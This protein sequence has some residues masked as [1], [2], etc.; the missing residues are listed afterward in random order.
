MRKKKRFRWQG[1]RERS[2][3][4]LV[5]RDGPLRAEAILP[6][7]RRL[8]ELLEDPGE[9]A[10]RRLICPSCVLVDEYG[11]PRLIERECS[12]AEWGTYLPPEQDRPEMTA[13]SEK[14]YALGMLMLYMASGQEKKAEA[15]ISLGG[16]GLHSVIRRCTAFDPM[17]RFED[18]RAVHDAV[19]REMR[20]GR[21]AAPVVLLLLYAAAVTALVFAAWR[22][23]G[24][25]GAE[26][27]DTAGYRPGYADGYARGSSAAPGIV[28]RGAPVNG[29]CGS[30]SGN[31]AAPDGPTA[32]YSEK[33]V[34]FLL[35]GDI[36]RMDAVTGKT[37]L[38]R[39]RS[40]AY[41]LQYYQGWLYC[42]TPE[43]ILRIDPE[44]NREEVYCDSLG[45]RLSIFD[46]VFYLYDSAG[47]HYLYR[48][49]RTGKSLKQ[50]SGAMEYRCLNV[51]GGKLYY[52]DPSRGNGICS[53]D[54]DGG[55]ANLISSSSYE[56]FCIY[57]GKITV[58]TEY[59]LIR[60]DLNGGNPEI[61]TSQPAYFP[62]ASESGVFYISG[63]GR[64]LEWMSGD[65]RTRLTVVSSRTAS[66][67][68]AGQWILYQNEDDGGRLWR[69]RVSGADNERAGLQQNS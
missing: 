50:I 59:G 36:L 37:E 65:G 66:F 60:M 26:A 64:T 53:S 69:V 7:I 15:E 27:G 14:V 18:V 33:E 63:S 16:T 54:P 35:D 48:I 52:I 40:G 38:L 31:Y 10:G 51:A 20:V 12:R 2:I 9:L 19:K 43:H 1:Q 22:T 56:S 21:K 67:Q 45:G 6:I 13:Q 39:K 41:S 49:S 23:G 55:D 58:G 68:L 32:A 46:D 42:C 25:R 8:C 30:L 44:T 61:L 11:E 3:S 57:D 47:T 34:F 28:V 4:E 17:N 24:A 62:N 29:S 5:S